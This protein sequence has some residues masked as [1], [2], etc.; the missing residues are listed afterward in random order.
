MGWSCT[1]AARD[2]MGRLADACVKASASR[3][4]FPACGRWFFW[5]HDPVEHDVG[6]ITGTVMEELGPRAFGLRDHARRAPPGRSRLDA[7]GHWHQHDGKS[8]MLERFR[9]KLVRPGRWVLAKSSDPAKTE[10]REVIWLAIEARHGPDDRT[11]S[12]FSW[13]YWP[14]WRCPG[15]VAEKCYLTHRQWR[16]R[17]GDYRTLSRWDLHL[18]DVCWD[19]RVKFIKSESEAHH[20]G[21]GGFLYEPASDDEDD[22]PG[23]DCSLYRCGCCERWVEPW[24]DDAGDLICPDCEY[25]G[26]RMAA[27]VEEYLEGVREVAGRLGLRSQLEHQIMRLGDGFFGAEALTILGKDFAPHSFTFATYGPPPPRG[28]RSG[29]KPNRKLMIHGG[30][31]YQ[32]PSAPGDGSF[33]TLCV[34]LTPDN[35]WFLHT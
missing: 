5:E 4:R 31:I 11:Q 29:A 24:S 16:N 22:C 14:V 3:Y 1:K 25:R 13:G 27:E 28:E 33:Q 20:Q 30:L 35:G 10:G 23:P 6:R 18:I 21:R 8:L 32:G 12:G 17:D 19:N 2:A 7:P 15:A 34:S 26:L 9:R